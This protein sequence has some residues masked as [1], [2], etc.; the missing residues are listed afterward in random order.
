MPVFDEY[1]E[2]IITASSEIS[3]TFLLPSWKI[4]AKNKVP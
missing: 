4:C 3:F 2:S 1:A